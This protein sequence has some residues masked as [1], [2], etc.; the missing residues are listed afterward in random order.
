MRVN[1]G[2]MTLFRRTRTADPAVEDLARDVAV[3]L[4][5]PA[6]TEPDMVEPAPVRHCAV[7]RD[8]LTDRW[9]GVA[10]RG[11]HTRC[12]PAPSGIHTATA[13]GTPVFCPCGEYIRPGE[14]FT[15]GAAG[16]THYGECTR[17]A[18]PQ[19]A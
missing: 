5:L 19:P 18:V 13:G 12:V 3:I 4:G 9:I 1:T 16:P 17:G 8:V 10:G 14:R 6:P 2:C 15:V 7:C 11:Y